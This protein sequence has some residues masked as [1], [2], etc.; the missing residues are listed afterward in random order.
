MQDARVCLIAEDPLLEHRL[1]VEMKRQAA[2]ILGA[3][4][5]EGPAR[6]DLQ[7]VIDAVAV[8]T[9]SKGVKAI[10]IS[11]MPPGMQRTP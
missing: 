2:R 8:M 1:I 6:F 3:R 10:V 11:G 7:H 4:S 9:N 5:F